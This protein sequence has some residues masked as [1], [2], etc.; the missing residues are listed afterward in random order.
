MSESEWLAGHTA[1]LQGL[2][3]ALHGPPV[4][5]LMA[6]SR[7]DW[8]EAGELCTT[9]LRAVE[10]ALLSQDQTDVE[11]QWVLDQ[12][13]HP[14]HALGCAAQAMGC[15]PEHR[16]A[17]RQTKASSLLKQLQSQ[18]DWVFTYGSTR[19]ANEPVFDSMMI[20]LSDRIAGFFVEAAMYNIDLSG[21]AADLES[22]NFL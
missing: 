6:W 19:F 21:S 2:S 9:W 11:R 22:G 18:A 10:A 3:G 13:L 12:W 20:D 15:A 17:R 8:G 14:I 16:H 7:Q 5:L 1:W 4:E